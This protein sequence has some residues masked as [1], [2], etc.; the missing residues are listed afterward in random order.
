MRGKLK[1]KN[2]GSRPI[3]YSSINYILTIVRPD[4]FNG[5]GGIFL[6]THI[7]FFIGVVGF[8]NNI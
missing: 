2:S 8:F 1:D 3:N 6:Q 7:Y 5:V 4:F